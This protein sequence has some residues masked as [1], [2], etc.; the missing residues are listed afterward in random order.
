MSSGTASRSAKDKAISVLQN[1]AP[2]MAL[3]E[4]EKRRSSGH[5]PWGG[6]RAANRFEREQA[7]QSSSS[8]AVVPSP[9]EE[10]ESEEEAEARR[11][12]KRQRPSLPPVTMRIMLTKFERWVGND[13]REE[14]ER[15][16][17]PRSCVCRSAFCGLTFGQEKTAQLW[18]PDR[19]GQ[20]AVRLSRGSVPGAHGKVPQDAVARP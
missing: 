10:E 4:K 14:V 20:P 15:V 16:S 5:G 6:K 18:H 2:D 8:P 12:A 1:L 13:A 9:K 17:L 7:I 3:Y 19:P 11:P